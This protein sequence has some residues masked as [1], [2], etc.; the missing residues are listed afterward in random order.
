MWTYLNTPFLFAMPGVETEEIE[1]WQE[2]GETWRRLKATF[3]PGIATHSTVQ[4]FYFD[5]T[6]LLKRHD[7]D[8]EIAGGN[9]AAHYVPELKEFSEIVVP[10]KR[11]VLQRRPDGMSIPDPVIVSIDLS[12]IEFI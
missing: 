11:R 9:P 3:P 4:T 1:P 12:E 6:G 10:T 2:N 5:Q 7:Y 8:V